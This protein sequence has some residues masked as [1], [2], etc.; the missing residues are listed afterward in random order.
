MLDKRAPE[1]PGSRD[2]TIIEEGV[3]IEG[4][5]YSRGSTKING[6]VKGEVIS[7]K[8]LIIGRE[9]KVEANIKTKT[10]IISG[11][12]R[13]EMIASGEVEITATGRFIGNLTQKGTFLSVQKGGLFKGKSIVA[14]NQDIYKIE[15]P[16]RPKAFFEQKPAFS[17][18]KTP[19]SQNS[20]NIRNPIP[21]RTEQNVKI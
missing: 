8:E 9:G 14:D 3:Y 7:E 2:W 4:R 20:F 16:E 18:I 21:S 11:S 15:V 17:L 1:L 5:I 19:P 10:S 13:G 12:F 6:V